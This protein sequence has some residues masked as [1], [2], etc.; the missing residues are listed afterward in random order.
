MEE[1]ILKDIEYNLT[2][3]TA[4]YFL[5]R[6]L[7]AAH[8]NQEMIHIANMILDSTLLSF[9]GLTCKYLPSQLAAGAVMAA[10]RTLGRYDWS[11]TL[12][13]YSQYCEEDVIP[14]AKAILRAKDG[15]KTDLIALQKKYSKT[16]YGKVSEVELASM[17]KELSD[18]EESDDEDHQE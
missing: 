14:V 12:L 3:P 11:P 10:R 5:V 16:K 17:D 9:A 13:Q 7:K 1:R 15:I 8:S 6:F 4:Y 18:K 2:V